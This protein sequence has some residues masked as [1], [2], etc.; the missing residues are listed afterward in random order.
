MKKHIK[1]FSMLA[2][3]LLAVALLPAVAGAV[4]PAIAEKALGIAVKCAG[5]LDGAWGDQHAALI[6][7]KKGAEFE[8]FESMQATIKGLLAGSG[9]T[10]I[11][12][13]YPSGAVESSPFIITV[14]G[15]P[16]PDDYGKAVE[17]EAG[18]AA[19]WGGAPVA[20]EEAEEDEGGAG[21]LLSAYAPIHD[22]KGAVVAILG[23][24]IPAK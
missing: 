8:G 20:A 4:D 17:W 14:D 18:F 21:L 11:Y 7:S 16:D 19:A 24:D 22:G 2:V 3:L 15:S 12:A 6:E 9:A 23:V 1:L 10:Y 5:Q 13:L